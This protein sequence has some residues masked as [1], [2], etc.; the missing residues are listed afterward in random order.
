M[1]D[2]DC[3]VVGARCGGATLAAH[4]SRAGMRVLALDADKLHSDQPFSTHVL[5][6]PAVEW[7]DELGVGDQLR[8]CTPPVFTSRIAV[9]EH[10]M[11]IPMPVDHPLYCPR[12]STLDP[13]L[14]DAAIAAGA[15]LRPETRVTE[16]LYEDGRVCGVRAEH[17]GQSERLRARWVIGAD[18]RNS[19]VARLLGARDYVEHV[20][21]RGGYWAYFPKPGCWDREDPYRRF[22]TV[23]QLDRV[24]HFAFECDGDL[25]VMGTFAPVDV[26]RGWGQRYREELLASLRRTP[27]TAALAEAEPVSRCLGLIKTRFYMREA[28]GPGWALVGDAGMHKDPTPGFGITDAMHDAAALAPALLDGRPE[29]LER[30]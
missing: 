1:T 29:A 7:L 27:L 10:A 25:L 8:A 6:T 23:I 14:Q 5:Q 11:D 9:R 30:F 28:A 2:Y 26:V 4:L 21:E 18:G 3:I 15:E 22:Q 24:A 17:A 12:R 19:T 13:L 16:L 20:S